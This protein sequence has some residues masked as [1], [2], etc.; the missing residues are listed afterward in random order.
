MKFIIMIIKTFTNAI[1]AGKV[2]QW[3][4]QLL[5]VVV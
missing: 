2:P 1:Q 5:C 4:K 3:L